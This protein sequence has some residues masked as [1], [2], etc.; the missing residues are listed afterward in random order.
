[1]DKDLVNRKC[2]PKVGSSLR[3]GLHVNKDKFMSFVV[4]QNHSRG[5]RAQSPA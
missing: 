1:M 3:A 4:H 2:S 5:M